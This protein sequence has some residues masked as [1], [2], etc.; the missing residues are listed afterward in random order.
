M[1]ILVVYP[2]VPYPVVRGTFQRTFHLLKELARYNEIDLFCLDEEGAAAHAPVFGAFCRRV[3][4]Q[5]FQHP[6]WPGIFGSRLIHPQPTT[7]RHWQ[8]E[9]AHTALA[10]FA[11]DQTYDLIHFCDLVLWPYVRRL[12]HPC[13]R[14]MDRSRVD[15]LFQT[16]ELRTLQLGTRDRLLRHENLWKL[17]RVERAAAR[18]LA[19]TVVCG[20]DDEVFMRRHVRADAPILVL[21]NGCD[22]TFFDQ[23]KWPPTPAADPTWLFCGAMDYSPNVDGI[24]WYFNEVDAAVR[25]ALP[26][27]VVKLVGKNPNAAVRAHAAVPGVVV[28]GEVPDVRPHY[29]DSWFQIVPLRIG[30]GTRLKIVESLC[31]GCPVL[32]T[33]I[34]AQGLDLRDGEHLLLADTPAEFAAAARR[35]AGDAALRERLRV[36]GRR[37]VLAHYSWPTLAAQLQRF[38]ES[39]LRRP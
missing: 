22:T 35:L 18:D 24:G 26:R 27:R 10:A 8:D 20:P 33:T 32:S 17:K 3:F 1:R 6:P 12:P 14:V 39:L 2:Y 4:F 31:I 5:P 13:P 34:G 11:R 38:Y 25:A 23:D 9:A 37:Q 29:Q 15:L 36:A 21:A 28:T 19:A 30:G 16:E 7:M